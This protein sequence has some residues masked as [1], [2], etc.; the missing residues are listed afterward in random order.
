MGSCRATSGCRVEL[1]FVRQSGEPAE[2]LSLERIVRQWRT[3]SHPHW[4]Q[5]ITCGDLVE[6]WDCPTYGR[7]CG[8][9]ANR[10]MERIRASRVA[11]ELRSSS[12]RELN[13]S[14]A[15]GFGGGMG[16]LMFWFYPLYLC[17]FSACCNLECIA[18]VYHFKLNSSRI[19]W[20]D[21]RIFDSLCHG[22]N[23]RGKACPIHHWTL[24]PLL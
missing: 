4:G 14:A 2:W 19:Y 16:K 18:L 24:E 10:G 15:G 6:V 23:D 13:E 11:V 1:S 20:P 21:F 7:T 22:E 3:C 17:G 5:E 12:P 8:M 9:S